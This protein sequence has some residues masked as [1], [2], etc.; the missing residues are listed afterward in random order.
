MRLAT[1]VLCILVLSAEQSSRS[2]SARSPNPADLFNQATK[3]SITAQPIEWNTNA[4]ELRGKLNQDFTFICPS[5]GRVGSVWGSD[6]YTDDSSI[7]SAAVHSG[8]IT[9]RD[10]GRVTIRIQPGAEFYN[11]TTRNGVSSQRY[12]AWQ[13]SFSFVR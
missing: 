2:A 4:A 11:G 7:C 10:G 5:S 9:A 12:G 13:G 8:L 1:L 3:Q 6:V